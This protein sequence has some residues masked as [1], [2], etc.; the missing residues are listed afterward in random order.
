MMLE[1][2]T[3]TRQER[4][5]AVV[6]EGSSEIKGAAGRGR[7]NLNQPPAP[8]RESAGNSTGSGLVTGS[9]TTANDLAGRIF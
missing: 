4:K 8:G 5:R 6:T 7:K 9:I 1:K 2:S 3:R